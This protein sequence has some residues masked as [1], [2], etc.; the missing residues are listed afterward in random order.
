MKVQFYT[1]QFEKEWNEFIQ[2]AKNATFLFH[3][4]FM[5]YHKDR[6][7]DRS[8][9]VFND[10]QELVSIL[11]ACLSSGEGCDIVSH[12]GLTYGGFVFRHGVKLGEVI[13]VVYHSLR[14]LN[15]LGYA[16]LVVKD[17]PS[18]YSAHPTDELEYAYFLLDARLY[19]RDIALVVDQENRIAYSGNIRRESVKAEKAG[20]VVAEE[21]SPA[22]FWQE[23]LVPNLQERFGVRPVHSV[24]E[25]C[26]L[27]ERFPFN[28][29]QYNVYLG[30]ELVAGTT[31]FLMPGVVHCQYIS[32]SEKGRK[33]GS[34]NYLFRCLL[35]NEFTGT[36][37]FDFGI[38]N[39]NDGKRINKGMLFWKESFGG[40]ARKHDFYQVPTEAFRRLE[41]YIS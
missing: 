22:S 35:D 36:R 26:L 5:D 10:R 19:R 34:L 29:R 9:L 27:K 32:A 7:T 1:G 16:N 38:V 6:F 4:A 18:F 3:R 37:F 12:Q 23:I 15:E 31:L 20:A 13:A 33:S 41:T 14:F 17:F 21:A 24:E 28:I 2:K 30:D 25:I 40:R 8:L 11:P 39:E